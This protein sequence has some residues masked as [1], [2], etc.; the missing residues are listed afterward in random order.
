MPLDETEQIT[1]PRRDGD[2]PPFVIP[3]AEVAE[4][5]GSDAQTGL[6]SAEAAT[7]QSRYGPNALREAAGVSPL[8]LL[9]E[10]FRNPLLIIL[11]VGA[12][13]SAYTGHWVDAVAIFVI[14]FINAAISFW[15]EYKAEA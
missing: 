10:Q 9:L 11:L 12:A 7:R 6:T 1:D 5:F 15:Q 8:M 2:T 13:L 4:R 3:L 14:V